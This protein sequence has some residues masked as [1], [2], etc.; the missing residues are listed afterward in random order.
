MSWPDDA[1]GAAGL[2]PLDR[3]A[4]RLGAA[5]APHLAD[6]VVP[7][8]RERVRREMAGVILPA[9]RRRLA[10][11]IARRGR[12]GIR[13]NINVLGEAILGE[14]EA[15]H[16]LGQL[17][18]ALGQPMVDYVSVKISSICSQLDVLGFD[19]EVD[20]IAARLRRLYDAANTFQPAKFV[21]LDMEEYRD[22]DLTLAVFRRVLD[23]APYATTGAGIVLQAYLPDSLPALEDLCA[24]AR[25][26]R[27]RTGGW[28]KVRLVKGANLAMEAVDAELHGWPAA[29]FASKDETDANYKRMLDVVLDSDNDGAVRAG[30][31]SHNL[32]EVAWAATQ[33]DLRGARHRVEFEMLEGMAPA[34]AEATA[35][36]LGGLLLYAPIVARGDIESAIAYLVRRLDENSGPDNFLTH[37]FSLEVGS[38]VWEAEADRFRRSVAERDRETAPT[39]RVQD[40]SSPPFR[41]AAGPTFRNEPDTDFSIAANRA[42]I[43]GH[44]HREALA[45]AYRPVV[46]GEGVEGSPSEAGIDPSAPDAAPAYRWLSASTD[47]VKRAVACARQAGPQWAARPPADRRAVLDGAA[48][49]LARRRGELLAVM[50]FDAAKTVREGDPEVSEAIDFAAYYGAHVP[51]AES[52]FR[53]FGTVVVAPPWNFPLSIPAGG[54]LA[55]LAAGNAVIFEARTRIGRGGSHS[56][57]GVVGGR[58]ASNRLA[59]RAVR[60]RP[61]QPGVDH[62]SGC[63]RRGVD[64]ILGD[65]PAFPRLATG[66]PIA[67]RDERQ[68]CHG[69]HGHR[70]PRRG[71]RRP[72]AVGI[73][74]RRPEVLGGQLGDRRSIRSRR[75][76]VPAPAGGRCSQRTGRAGLGTSSRRWGRSSGHPTGPCW[77]RS[78]GWDQGSDGWCRPGVSTQRGTCGRPA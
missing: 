55:A 68:E 5:L 50:A 76:A 6:V 2:G 56:G 11:H 44:L 12:E 54:V 73:W 52:G 38:P 65:G 53:P 35:D 26:R 64:R 70:R 60:R 59:V 24:W 23:E 46:A 36:R 39:R 43:A 7:A 27:D 1:P 18:D 3:L 15:E 31:A 29:P 16:R 77:R 63:R 57:G 58:R 10:R 8:V 17:L 45:R 71:H 34:V 41:A 25:K 22:L 9:G 40:R 69:H 47:V 4:L 42:W 66:P 28:I 37:S 21:N 30:V 61:R 14:D 32:F 19:H 78:P 33:A 51:D 13:L 72:G 20:R 49:A 67:R 62:P 75:P 74:P 48:D